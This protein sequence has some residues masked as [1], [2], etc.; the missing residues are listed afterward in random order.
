MTHLFLLIAILIGA[1]SIL[2]AQPRITAI[3]N[4]ADHST[5]LAP[6]SLATIIG[7]GLAASAVQLCDRSDS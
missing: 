3:G 5:P 2:E 7:T 6:G 1:S 4:A